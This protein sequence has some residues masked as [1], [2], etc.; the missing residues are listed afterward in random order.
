MVKEKLQYEEFI[1]CFDKE[2]ATKYFVSHKIAQSH[3]I[4]HTIKFCPAQFAS[5]IT[6]NFNFFF[7]CILSEA[8]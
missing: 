6:H 2:L 8:L 1:V 4:S 5:K 7:F 3:T